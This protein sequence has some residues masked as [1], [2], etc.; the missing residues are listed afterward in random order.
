MAPTLGK[1]DEGAVDL[2]WRE[3]LVESTR[4]S[5]IFLN[6]VDIAYKTEGAE[7]ASL[8]MARRKGKVFNPHEHCL[9]LLVRAVWCH[10]FAV[11]YKIQ[12]CQCALKVPER[13][14]FPG[15]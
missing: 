8:K 1:E 7:P 3:R 9:A 13:L 11:Y 2:G 12:N 5:E 10:I 4:S 15:N 14:E 6:V